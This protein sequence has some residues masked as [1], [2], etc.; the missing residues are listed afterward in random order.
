MYME[1]TVHDTSLKD[2]NYLK[3][4]GLIYL[5]NSKF[6]TYY[7]SLSNIMSLL[8]EESR[9]KVCERAWEMTPSAGLIK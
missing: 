6:I 8:L 5:L 9:K 1:D 7:E 2:R 4:S 3:S